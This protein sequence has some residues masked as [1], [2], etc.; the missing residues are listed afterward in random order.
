M[1]KQKRQKTLVSVIIPAH[2]EEEYILRTIASIRNQ[3]YTNLEIIVVVN[4]STDRTF[5]IAEKK[6]DIA[7]DFKDGFGPA[8]ARNKGAEVA[9]GSLYVFVDAD[10]LL[11]PTII[12]NIVRSYELL[13]TQS[14]PAFGACKALPSRR[15]IPALAFFGFKN[16]IHHLHLY[17]GVLALFFCDAQLFKNVT[18]FKPQMRVGEFKDFIRRSIEAGGRYVFISNGYVV[19]SIRRFDQEG[20]V[21]TLWFWIRWAFTSPSKKR[22]S[23][24]H[25]IQKE[26]KP[27]R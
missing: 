14:M 27:I 25:S 10:T 24:T 26:Y 15:T 7:L 8:Q 17:K 4:G 6:A 23:G 3:S 19:T 16:L 11:S 1:D 12:A 13:A 5:N 21:R 18:G 9:H 2:N 22:R 20:Y